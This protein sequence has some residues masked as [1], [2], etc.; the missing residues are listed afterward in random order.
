MVESDSS[1]R[2]THEQVTFW[3]EKGPDSVE[4]LKGRYKRFVYPPH[5]HDRYMIGLITQ[6]AIEIVEPKR[7]AT[8]SRGQVILYNVD[9]VHW[10]H[11]ASTD[12]WTILAT[13]LPEQMLQQIASDVGST[14]RGTI[15]FGEIS[16]RNPE[17]ARGI[18]RLYSDD[19]IEHESLR[20]RSLLLDIVAQALTLHADR[21]IRSPRVRSEDR[22]VRI[23]REFLNSN[24]SQNVSLGEL[25][26]ECGISR[27]WLIKAFKSQ[28][29]IPPYAYLTNVRIRHA[30][31]L[32][33]QGA[34][35]V[36]VAFEC[37]F[38]DQSH[39]T[40]TFKR[41]VGVTPGRFMAQ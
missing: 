29:G 32:L 16:A 35:P 7:R 21:F 22:A 12:G 20:R 18:A 28:V 6:G 31:S 17:M 38:S 2:R 24:F 23:A 9:Q 34:Q 30:I 15:A 8:V 26:G 13:Y 4:F 11:E 41:F 1:R 19:D 27:Y 10:G 14:P 33:R 40:R 37:G 39:L 5:S 36:K 25:A 3:R